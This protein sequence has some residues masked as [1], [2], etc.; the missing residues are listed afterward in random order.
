MRF[1][2]SFDF[3]HSRHC[4]AFSYC[5]CKRARCLCAYFYLSYAH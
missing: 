5:R 2:R 3:D 4:P 1:I